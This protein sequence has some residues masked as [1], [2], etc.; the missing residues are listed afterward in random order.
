[1]PG[2]KIQSV[3]IAAQITP[4]T[5]LFKWLLYQ[6]SNKSQGFKAPFVKIWVFFKKRAY[7]RNADKFS[8]SDCGRYGYVFYLPIL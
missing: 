8:N 7:N 1:M 6:I 5:P 2:S 3:D 4:T